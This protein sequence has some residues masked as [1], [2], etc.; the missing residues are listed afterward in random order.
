MTNCQLAFAYLWV[1]FDIRHD[2]LGYKSVGKLVIQ[3][4]SK[5]GLIDICQSQALD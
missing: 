3:G 1:E 2:G 4:L 5:F